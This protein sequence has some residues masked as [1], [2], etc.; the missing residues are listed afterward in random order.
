METIKY[1][2]DRRDG[3]S[4]NPI[5]NPVVKYDGSKPVDYYSIKSAFQA[6]IIGKT[7]E[8]NEYISDF[9]KLSN[10]LAKMTIA[11]ALLNPFQ[12]FSFLFQSMHELRHH[13]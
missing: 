9:F 3:G 7:M 2:G 4:S 10:P 6:M 12:A 11:F 1:G 13:Q 5:S 8:C